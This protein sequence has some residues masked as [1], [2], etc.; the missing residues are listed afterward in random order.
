MKHTCPV[1]GSTQINVVWETADE[2]KNQWFTGI[3]TCLKHCG[4]FRMSGSIRGGQPVV[5]SWHPECRQHGTEAVVISEIDQ[6]HFYCVKCGRKM[7]VR[8]GRIVVTWQPQVRTMK[9]AAPINPDNRTVF[10]AVTNLDQ[11]Q[12]GMVSHA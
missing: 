10:W 4:I 6:K 11:K 9:P 7:E 1:C 12:K 3:Y 8:N 5:H 2:D